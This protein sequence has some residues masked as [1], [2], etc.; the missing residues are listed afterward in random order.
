[1]QVYDKGRG[2][3]LAQQSRIFDRFYRLDEARV[4]STGGYRL[5]L[6]IVKTLVE[7]MGGSVSVRSKLGEGSVFTVTLPAQIL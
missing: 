7:G 1:M 3:P 6:L 5:G 2:I 4:R